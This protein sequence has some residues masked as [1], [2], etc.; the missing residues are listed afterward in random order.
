MSCICGSKTHLRTNHAD[1]RFNPNAAIQ[2]MNA[3]NSSL[4]KAIN[5]QLGV[6]FSPTTSLLNSVATLNLQ[7]TPNKRKATTMTNIQISKK[8]IF[9]NNVNG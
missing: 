4:V 2:K 5:N 8:L 6:P 7:V 1:C 3:N 9:S